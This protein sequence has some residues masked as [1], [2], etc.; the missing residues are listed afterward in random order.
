MIIVLCLIGILTGLI[1]GLTGLGG[2]IIIIPALLA[3]FKSQGLFTTHVM[4]IAAN[5]SLMIVL[6]TNL[7]NFYQYQKNNLI[8]WDMIKS[9]IPGLIIGIILGSYFSNSLDTESLKNIFALF[10]IFVGI[11]LLR[12]HQEVSSSH[13]SSIYVIYLAGISTGLLAPMFGIGGGI[14]MIPFFHAQGLSL[15]KSIGSSVFCLIPIAIISL[16]SNTILGYS[17]GQLPLTELNIIAY[18]YW[19]GFLCIASMSMFMAPISAKIAKNS[20]IKLIKKLLALLIFLTAIHLLI[21]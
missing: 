17:K 16:I 13:Q 19:P 6:F 1:S 2:G 7:S 15:L 11:H 8:D 10:L 14:L 21:N 20:N 9:F 18:I 5:T 4:Q 12:T 3:W